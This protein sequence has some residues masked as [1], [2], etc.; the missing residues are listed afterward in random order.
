VIYD[1]ENAFELL[2]KYIQ[3]E[4]L[5]KHA[6]AVEAVMKRFAVHFGE[7]ENRYAVLGLLHDLD[8]ELYPAEHCKHTGGML[9]DAG[10]P[11]ADIKAVLSHG[12][13]LCTDIEPTENIEK[14]LFTIDELT[15]LVAATALMRPSKSCSDLELKSLKKKWK[16]KAF[17]AGCNREIIQ[18]GC[19]M[20]GMSLDDVMM[21]TI[22]GMR[23][24][25]F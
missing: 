4:S 14:V 11:D 16:D 6:L 24:G 1:R 7:D 10:Y 9:K 20:L 8:Y 12:Y 23:D 18:K 15:G 3:S 21:L 13:T 19:D 22:E 5:I 25:G 17:A 2:K